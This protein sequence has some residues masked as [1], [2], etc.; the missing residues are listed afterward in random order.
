MKLFFDTSALVKKY[1]NEPGSDKVD[2][3]MENAD[4]IYIS[5][6]TEIEMLSTFKRLLVEKA[7]TSNDYEILTNEFIFDYQYFNQITF[8]QDI[9]NNAKKII[10]KYQLKSLDSIQLGTA[11]YLENSFDYFIACDEKLLKA[12]KKVNIETINPMTV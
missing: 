8:D 1:I 4:Q 10:E 2:E 3:L 11:V 6:I 9:S 12:G 7:I 5:V